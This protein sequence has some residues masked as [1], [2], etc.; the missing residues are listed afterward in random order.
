MTTSTPALDAPSRW[1]AA[2]G[3]RTLVPGERIATAEL[4]AAWRREDEATGAMTAIEPRTAAILSS[5]PEEIAFERCEAC[6]LEMAIPPVVWSSA[7]YPR[8]QSY[9][10]RWEFVR[11]V[12]D[13]GDAPKDVLEIGCGEGHFLAM[14]ARRGHRAV[15]IDFSDTAVAKARAR[16]LRA[17]CGGFDELTRHLGPGARFDAVALFQVIEH[18]AN[19]DEVLSALAAWTRPGATLL[20]SCPGPRRFTR[21]IREQQ[22]GERDFWDYPPHHVLRWTTSALHAVVAR[23]GWRVVTAM[24]EPFSWLA[25]GSHIGIARA[26]HRGQLNDPLRRR[27][28]IAAAWI[29]LL[30]NAGRYAGMSLYM[31]AVHE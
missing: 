21:L 6:G 13:L 5:L 27:A 22:A 30:V 29:R 18:L 2:C 10:V 1:C 12:D 28:S 3:G 8:D 24:E 23:H 16:G 19:P 4:A 31:C 7:A 9:P 25:A 15:G 20:V 11:G 26:I 14:A 17:F